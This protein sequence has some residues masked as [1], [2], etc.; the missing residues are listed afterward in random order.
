[1]KIWRSEIQR[2]KY[3]D[4]I[5]IEFPW[6]KRPVRREREKQRVGG[7][8]KEHRETTGRKEAG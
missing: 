5:R 4:A 8:G 7:S 2:K 1:L 6:P 3:A